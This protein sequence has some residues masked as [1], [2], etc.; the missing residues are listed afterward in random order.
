MRRGSP[1]NP[2]TSA[3]RLAGPATAL[4]RYLARMPEKR[5]PTKPEDDGPTMPRTAENQWVATARAGASFLFILAAAGTA[6]SFAVCWIPGAHY[7]A[8]VVFA[9]AAL[10]AC[11]LERGRSRVLPVALVLY[12]LPSAWHGYHEY[13][14]YRAWEDTHFPEIKRTVNSAL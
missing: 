13:N 11:V 5:P 6:L 12:V 8:H 3:E 1:F 2:S 4:G 10:P 9:V 7:A 14:E